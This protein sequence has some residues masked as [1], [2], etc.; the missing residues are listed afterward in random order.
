MYHKPLTYYEQEVQGTRLFSLWVG[1]KTL[2][3]SVPQVDTRVHKTLTQ[4]F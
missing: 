3:T 1:S 4:A 2:W